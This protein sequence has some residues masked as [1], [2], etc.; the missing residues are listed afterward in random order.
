MSVVT[1]AHEPSDAYTQ[2][3]LGFW[4]YLMGRVLVIGPI[5][6]GVLW[7]RRR[8]VDVGDEA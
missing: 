4:L 3:A 1:P 2:R 8:A 6:N 7:R 5:L